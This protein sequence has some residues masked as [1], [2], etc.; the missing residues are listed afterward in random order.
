VKLIACF[1]ATAALAATP[2]LTATTA[3]AATAALTNVTPA[4]LAGDTG[5]AGDAAD[6]V[7]ALPEAPGPATGLADSAAL[8]A[9]VYGPP[10]QDIAPMPAKVPL[11]E[12][13]MRMPWARPVPGVFWFNRDLRV[14][15]SSQDKPAPLAIVISGTGGDGNTS[16][17][18]TLRGALYGAGYHVLTLPSPTFPGFI[19][20]A[21]TTGVAGDLVQDGHDLY[22]A[23]QRVVAHLPGKVQITDIDILGYSLGGANAGVV[24]SIDASEHKL[25]IHRAVMIEPP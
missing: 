12:I 11:V 6:Q 3:L 4:A 8:R 19:V 24:K 21:S 17:L 14:W 23:M 15:F 20:S 18:S 25:N 9:T 22:L 13:N 7:I 2:A 10:P 16:V 1:I 5:N